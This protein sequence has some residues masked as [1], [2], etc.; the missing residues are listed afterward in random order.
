MPLVITMTF[1]DGVLPPADWKAVRRLRG[2]TVYSYYSVADVT[3]TDGL[4]HRV[5]GPDEATLLENR[6]NAATDDEL[7]RI[8]GSFG[9][10]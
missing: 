3:M 6:L 4:V 2:R 8:F 10:N 1:R 5:S 7:A 9:L